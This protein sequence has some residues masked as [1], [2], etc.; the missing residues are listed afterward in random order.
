[1]RTPRP[2]YLAG[3]AHK[4]DADRDFGERIL[5]AEEAGCLVLN[6]AYVYDYG[7]VIKENTM[8]LDKALTVPPDGLGAWGFYTGVE[9]SGNGTYNLRGS[10]LRRET[11]KQAVVLLR[12]GDG[13]HG[14]WLL[15]VLPRVLVAKKFVGDDATFVVAAHTPDYQIEMLEALG[16]S[17]DRLFRLARDEALLCEELYVP[18]VA[19][20]NELW[21]HPFANETYNELIRH[22]NHRQQLSSSVSRLLFVTRGTRERDPRPLLNYANLEEIARANEYEIVDPGVV[23]WHDQIRLFSQ[24]S[25]IVGLCGS[26]LHNTVFTGRD[27]HVC[28]LQPNQNNN[29]LQSSIAAIR[30]HEVSYLLGEAFSA[31]DKRTHDAGYIVDPKLF[32][33]LLQHLL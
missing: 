13:V 29:F 25:K 7:L 16:V 15:E 1:M 21:V 24:A 28:T 6:G 9:R 10:V 17:R 22:V 12:R 27:A 18:S 3:A 30:G 2:R 14:H 33:L 19:H 31:F 26:G 20:T 23:P 5:L 4:R 32:K 8:L 11:V